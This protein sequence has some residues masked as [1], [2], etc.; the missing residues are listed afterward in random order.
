MFGATIT[1]VNHPLWG[2]TTAPKTRIL[3]AEPKALHLA[4]S[5]SNQPELEEALFMTDESEFDTQGIYH[6]RVQGSLDRKWSD[7][8]DGFTITPQ[9]NA[10][11]AQAA[12]GELSGWL[13]TRAD[14]CGT[15]V[16]GPQ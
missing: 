3:G 6:I 12:N 9:A 11:T 4:W 1:C 16:P 15:M 2:M 5:T 14:L 10:E 13:V 8:F 7:W